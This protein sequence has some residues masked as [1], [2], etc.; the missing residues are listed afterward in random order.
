MNLFTRFSLALLS[1]NLLFTGSTAVPHYPKLAKRL[2]DNWK[3]Y[4]EWVS[5]LDVQ[6]YT[7]EGDACGDMGTF[8]RGT[9]T[10]TWVTD[11]SEEMVVTWEKNPIAQNMAAVYKG[12]L[13]VKKDGEVQ[14][15]QDVAVKRD[16]GDGAN[17][18]VYGASLQMRLEGNENILG[19]LGAVFSNDPT[20]GNAIMAYVPATSL[21]QNFGSYSNQDSV[22]SAFKQILSAVAAV[23]SAGI[24]HRDLKPENFLLDGSTLKL[25]DFD[26]AIEAASSDETNVGT[27]T[28]AAPEIVSQKTK[29]G[30]PYTNKVDTF[31][32]GMTFLV[33]S[34]PELRD[35]NTRFDL[36][37]NLIEPNDELWP[38]AST[39]ASILKGKN[40]GVFSGNDNLLNVLS[41][42]LCES[43]TR[44][45]PQSFKSAFEN[46]V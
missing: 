27:A 7:Y 38:S 40:Y 10:L 26:T 35:A 16:R 36:W 32:I 25:I 15:T 44:Y 37:R 6:P 5:M 8:N 21:E 14:S 45:D 19:A 30:G 4:N 33:M 46:A 2:P 22:N 24:I 3:L 20:A 41:N 43:D 9:R 42:A 18:V 23:Q 28:Y 29:S 11:N 12:T 13:Q 34:V 17:G 1:T 39:V 31:S